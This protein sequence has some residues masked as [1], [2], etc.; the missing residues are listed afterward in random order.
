M[1]FQSQPILVGGNQPSL[2]SIHFCRSVATDSRILFV[3]L[4]LATGHGCAAQ[5][6]M[7]VDSLG[8]S[9]RP[10]LPVALRIES[11]PRGD[12]VRSY[13][14]N[15][16]RS[17]GECA[18]NNKFRMTP[19]TAL[20]WAYCPEENLQLTF[21]SRNASA[22][23][24]THLLALPVVHSALRSTGSIPCHSRQSLSRFK[25]APINLPDA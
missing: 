21:T 11:Q 14:C 18:S 17:K 4:G 1:G 2:D 15:K 19:D 24:P 6:T 12:R 22:I 5:A 3:T 8:S 7:A 9:S 23:R 16:E 25:H 10:G 13:P 20:A